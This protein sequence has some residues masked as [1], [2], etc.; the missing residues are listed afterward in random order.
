MHAG[1]WTW[2]RWLAKAQTEHQKEE[3]RRLSESG[4]LH[5]AKNRKL[6]ITFTKIWHQ[7]IRK[8]LPGL[9]SL[10]FSYNIQM[11]GSE[12]FISMTWKYKSVLLCINSSGL[13]WCN[14]VGDIFLAHFG[15]F[16]TNYALF[17]HHKLSIVA[18]S[19]H[20]F[21]PQ[22]AQLPVAT[23]GKIMQDVKS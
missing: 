6:R 16:S 1:I 22:C 8:T 19:V 3:E 11:E 4:M 23:S 18:D 2:G 15:P 13:W 12:F 14:G 5:A 10:Y 21:I 7:M 17:K 9:M 20:P